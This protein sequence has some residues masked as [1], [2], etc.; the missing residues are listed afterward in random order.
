MRCLY[1]G[2]LYDATAAASSSPASPSTAA[3]TSE[4]RH[5]GYPCRS[6]RHRVRLPRPRRAAAP[7]PT[8]SSSPPRTSSASSRRSS[9]TAIT[10][11]ETR[12]TRTQ[13]ALLEFCTRSSA[14]KCP[15]RRRASSSWRGYFAPHDRSGSHG[16]G[17]AHLR[18]TAGGAQLQVCPADQRRDAESDG[19]WRLR[20]RVQRQLARGHRRL[21][22]LEVRHRLSPR[23]ADEPATDSAGPG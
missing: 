7:S 9:R 19:L 8:T 18:G 23:R 6:E 4:I 1:H 20:G 21:A 14:R 17:A 10:C 22:P 11:R 3:S 13:S 12:A 16:L 5:T 15:T 2:W